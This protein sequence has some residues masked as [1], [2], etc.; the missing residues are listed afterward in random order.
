[1][2]TIGIGRDDPRHWVKAAYL[3]ID[4]IEN[5]E[6]G[7]QEGTDARVRVTSLKDSSPPVTADPD[8]G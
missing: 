2:V 8:A 5:R 7:P 4:A 3:L 1:M 6:A